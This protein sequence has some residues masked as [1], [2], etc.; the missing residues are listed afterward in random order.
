MREFQTILIDNE[1]QITTITLNRPTQRNAMNPQMHFEMCDALEEL[2][3]D[4]RTRVLVLTG[5]GESFCGGQDLKE[6]FLDL[7][8]DPV[9]RSRANYASNRWRLQLLRFFPAP[10]IAMVNGFCFG[11]AMGV[12]AACDLA[13]AAEEATFGLSEINWGIFPGSSLPTALPELV[14]FRDVMYFT[15]TGEPF[16]GRKA[17]EIRFVNCAAPRAQ[18]KDA[19][20]RLAKTLIEKDPAALKA[21][22]E[23]MKLGRHMNYEE[24]LAWTEAKG[25]ELRL[26]TSHRWKKGVQQFKAGKY[27]PG[28]EGYEW[29]EA[30]EK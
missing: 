11:G 3:H 30:K 23:V 19:T 27:R 17:A 1:D 18:L 5:A 2:S 7:A 8:D 24:T 14:P 16:D 4:P 26:S 28:M 9:G 25:R 29:Q 21:A 10:S 13:I 20:W 6:F 12:V 15:L 22:K